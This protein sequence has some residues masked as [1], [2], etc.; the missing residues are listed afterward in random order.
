MYAYRLLERNRKKGL[1]SL[2]HVS[3][4]STK[5]ILDT[6]VTQDKPDGSICKLKERNTFH[7][8]IVLRNN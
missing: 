1:G 2:E 5:S 3:F 7:K 8:F 4:L 6:V